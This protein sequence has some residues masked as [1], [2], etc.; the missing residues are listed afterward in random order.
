MA[1]D[2]FAVLDGAAISAVPFVVVEMACKPRGKGDPDVRIVFPKGGGRPFPQ[3]YK[4]AEDRDYEDAIAWKAKA[5]MRGRKMIAAG[6]PVAVRMFI[7]VP[8]AKSWPRRDRD[9]AVAGTMF[10]TGRPDHDNYSKSICDALTG[11][12]WADD[13]QICRSLIVKEYGE[14]PGIIVEVYLLP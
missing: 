3:T 10:P 8:I 12:V 9:A 13:S 1:T 14:N 7:I 4:T 6:C 5:A 11:I 2:L